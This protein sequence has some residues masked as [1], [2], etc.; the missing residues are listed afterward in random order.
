MAIDCVPPFLR[1]VVITRLPLKLIA[2][3]GRNATCK[4]MLPWGPSVMGNAGLTTINSGRVLDTLRIDTVCRPPLVTTIEAVG[5][6][7]FTGTDPKL[8]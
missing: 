5:L 6:V 8:S 3:S 4:D 1:L 7:V 2:A